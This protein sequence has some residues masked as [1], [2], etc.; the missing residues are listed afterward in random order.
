[1]ETRGT[2]LLLAIIFGSMASLV[3]VVLVAVIMT[4]LGYKDTEP[5]AWIIGQVALWVYFTW[6]ALN[7][8]PWA[9]PGSSGRP[10]GPIREGRHGERVYQQDGVRRLSIVKKDKDAPPPSS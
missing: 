8:N 3:L 1:M 6:L 4:L 9:G 5:L 10:D 7:H 2:P